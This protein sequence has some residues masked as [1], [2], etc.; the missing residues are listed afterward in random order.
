MRSGLQL[1]GPRLT[2]QEARRE[3]GAPLHFTL[4]HL[5]ERA[6]RATDATLKDH[7]L[8][9]LAARARSGHDKQGSRSVLT[10]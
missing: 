9:H 1:G 7:Y 6:R 4:N 5:T 3:P 8:R 10:A 2:P